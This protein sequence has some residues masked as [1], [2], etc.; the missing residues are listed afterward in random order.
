M[1]L[2]HIVAIVGAGLIV[3]GVAMIAQALGLIVLGALLL[4]FAVLREGG[5]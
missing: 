5:F 1:K 4:S 3:A 2:S